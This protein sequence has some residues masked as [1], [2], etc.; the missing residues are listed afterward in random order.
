MISCEQPPK[1]HSHPSPCDS[2]PQVNRM[3]PK[4][5]AFRRVPFFIVV[6][7][8]LNVPAQADDSALKQKWELISL[9]SENFSMLGE[10]KK[11]L[12]PQ[13]V[14]H[15]VDFGNSES[16]LIQNLGYHLSKQENAAKRYKMAEQSL[17]EAKAEYEATIANALFQ[18]S[19]DVFF[20]LIV[21]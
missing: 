14:G 3:H 15:A 17:S 21:D 18:T 12:V 5:A 11:V 6:I 2:Q 20:D 1:R 13:R 7:G 10:N 9:A 8:F 4:T 19:I 16:S